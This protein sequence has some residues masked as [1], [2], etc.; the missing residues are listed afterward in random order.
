M[1]RAGLFLS[2]FLLPIFLLLL[3]VTAGATL[4]LGQPDQLKQV[5]Q[6]SG[7]YDSLVPNLLV[8]TQAD[9]A[10]DEGISLSEPEVKA[11]VEKTFSQDV[12]KLAVDSLIDGIYPWLSG[13]A[14]EPTFKI[15][16]SQE[17]AA[18]AARVAVAAERHADSLPLCA[19]DGAVS[20]SF[21][22]FEA[23]CLPPGITPAQAGVQA[24][25]AVLNAEGFLEN[26]VVT[27]DN[28]KGAGEDQNIFA[29]QLKDVPKYY[30]KAKIA[31]FVLAG[32]ALLTALGVILL[33][34]SRRKGWR[35]VGVILVISGVLILALAWALNYSVHSHGLPELQMD[36]AT[37]GEAKAV[38]SELTR[39]IDKNYWIIGGAYLGLGI[40]L[41]IAARFIKRRGKP[42]EP[43]PSAEPP[44]PPSAPEPP[45]QPPAEPPKTSAGPPPVRPKPKKRPILVQ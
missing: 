30:Q 39:S 35:R 22:V 3:A 5:I 9:E 36:S 7:V 40:L 20:A 6:K 17:R 23:E 4:V 8:Q 11:A 14:A 15:D 25:T 21:D 45:S 2:S 41:I 33:S 29:N 24:Q 18:L 43:A 13:Q 16:L 1:R 38:I 19:D 34:S 44:A 37:Q 28:L 31:P 12:V 26:P 10:D 42:A 32:F 27:A